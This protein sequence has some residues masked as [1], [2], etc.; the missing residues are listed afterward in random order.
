[1]NADDLRIERLTRDHDL[2]GFS[3][4]NH[5]LDSWLSR[6]SLTA[7]EMDS[8]RTFLLADGDAVVGYFSLTMGS[9]QREE[10]P[11]RLVR[12]MPAYPVG[13]VLLAR[14]AVDRREQGKGLGT[15]LLAEALRKAV[16]AGE[17]AAAWL[18][19]VN[20]IDDKAAAFYGRHGFTPVPEHP[21][22]LYRRMK[23]VRASLEAQ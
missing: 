11:K 9:V 3:S 7:Q 12:G 22:R 20:A 10:A 13:A 4:G 17:A 23:D 6:H 16:M 18:V 8:A 2:T 14:L 1:M 19:V 5:Q 21:L 15:L